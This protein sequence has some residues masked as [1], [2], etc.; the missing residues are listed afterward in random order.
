MVKIDP[1]SRADIIRTMA[2]RAR[3]YTPE[4]DPD[5]KNPD[6]AAA[7]ALACAGMFEGTIKKINGLPLKNQISLLPAIPSEGYVSFSLSA[8]DAGSA[9]VPKG[10]VVSSYSGDGDPVHFETLDDILVSSAVVSKAFCADGR[11]DRIGEYEFINTEPTELFSLPENDLQSHVLY[12]GHPYAFHLCSETKLA[13]SFSHRGGVPLRSD[14]IRMLTDKNA[15]S[16]E[17]YSKKNGYVQFDSVAE[18]DGAL[19]LTKGASQPAISEDEEGRQLRVTVKDIAAFRNF[20]F[21]QV[22][23]SPSGQLIMPDSISD[24]TTELEINAFY[25]FGE[26]FQLFNEVYFGCD[27]VLDKRGATVTMNFDLS[28]LQV[29]IENQL[30]D[31]EIKWKWIAKKSDFRERASYQLTITDVIWEYYNGYGWSRLFPD[32]SYSDIFNYTEGVTNCFRT[33]TFVCP[34]DMSSVFV[35]ARE[36]FYIRARVLKADNMYKLKGHFLSPFIRNLSFDYRYASEG[37]L[38]DNMICRNFQSRLKTGLCAYCGM[39]VRI[40]LQSRQD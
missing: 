8:E 28:F 39:F 21:A 14:D 25:A 3:S 19:I 35:G 13:I 40:R 29:P 16:V 6:I 7:L 24:G 1:R 4:W 11:L 26:R 20:R 27:E 30:P 31:D 36:G 18:K 22:Q 12:A 34:E 17:Y 5:F 38:I 15:V 37:C 32:R 33:M 2:E 23:A 9:E 10:T